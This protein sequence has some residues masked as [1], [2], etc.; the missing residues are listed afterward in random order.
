M[1]VGVDPVIQSRALV[2]VC[3]QKQIFKNYIYMCVC[4]CVRV[5]V[6]DRDIVHVLCYFLSFVVILSCVHPQLMQSSSQRVYTAKRCLSFFYND[7]Y[8]RLT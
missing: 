2:I 4:V 6:R 3:Q 1:G 5:C 8:Q 7:F